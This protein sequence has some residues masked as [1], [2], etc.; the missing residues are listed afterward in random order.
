MAINIGGMLLKKIY[1][2]KTFQFLMLLKREEV[3]WIP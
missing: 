3:R 1:A 2:G